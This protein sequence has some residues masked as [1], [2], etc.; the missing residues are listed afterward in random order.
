MTVQKPP[1]CISPPCSFGSEAVGLFYGCPEGPCSWNMPETSSVR[2]QIYSTSPLSVWKKLTVTSWVLKDY[3]PSNT[4]TTNK[5]QYSRQQDHKR[6]LAHFHLSV[7]IL[8][9]KTSTVSVSWYLTSS[10]CCQLQKEKLFFHPGA[11][12]QQWLVYIIQQHM[13]KIVVLQLGPTQQLFH[14]VCVSVFFFYV[15]KL[16]STKY[17]HRTNDVRVQ[18]NCLILRTTDSHLTDAV[19]R[20]RLKRHNH[21][22]LIWP[23]LSY[24]TK[25]SERE[26]ERK[27]IILFEQTWTETIFLSSKCS[28]TS[29]ICK[30][31]FS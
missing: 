31:I 20:D 26:R 18:R 14:C 4:V 19:F 28:S 8:T 7:A 2:H 15:H 29:H 17:V 24:Q 11:T 12:S 22:K 10:R 23:H 5:K 27:K 30:V 13:D 21:H 16:D 3:C 9:W 25:G 6:H 1:R